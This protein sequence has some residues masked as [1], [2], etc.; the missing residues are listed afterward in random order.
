MTTLF[1]LLYFLLPSHGGLVDGLPLG[2]LETVG[3]VLVV[4]IA[5]HRGRIPGAWVAAIL[6]VAA[7]GASLA[8]PGEPGLRGSY[9]ATATA[10]G[11]HE[12]STDFKD[13]N[14]TR[15][16]TRIDFARGGHEFPLAFMNDHTRFNFMRPGEPDRRYLEFAVAWT[17][18]WWSLA[19]TH[20]L[21][22]RAPKGIGQ[23]AVDGGT[24]AT[25][26]IESG[27]VLHD[28]QVSEG[29]H[30]LHVNF[31][32]PYGAP[33]MFSAGE[34][35]NGVLTPFDANSLRTERI[36]QRQGLVAA[37]LTAIKSVGDLVVLGWLSALAVLLIVR[38]AGELWQRGMA[39]W[40]AAAYLWM[41]AATLE[42]FRFAWPWAE[43]LRIMVAGDDTM[44]YEGYARDI[45]LRG[46]LMN[47][48]Q[49]LG[50]GEPF[51]YQAFYPYFLAST[52]AVF[53]EGFFGAV[54]LQRV[55]VA[56]TVIVLTRIAMKLRDDAVWPVGVLVSGL[57]LYWKL[58]PI[59]A[60]LLSESLYVP[61]LAASTLAI[62][63]CCRTPSNR[64]AVVAGLLS[65]FTA[66]TRSTSLLAWVAVWPMVANQARRRRAGV[67]PAVALIGCTLAVFALIAIR[68]GLVSY[69]FVPAS[70]EFGITL[71]GG[72][73][74]P[75]DLQLN[76]APREALYRSLN[77]GGHTAEV[78]EYAIAA[79]GRFAGNIGHKALFALGF[80]EGY[81]P[82]WGNSPVYIAAWIAAL[83]GVVIVRR[84][85]SD[86]AAM[87][88]L[89]VALT[90]YL[91]IVIVYPKGERLIVPIHTML[92]PYAVIAADWLLRRFGAIGS[93]ATPG[94]PG[95]QPSQS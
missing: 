70:T 87:V 51:Y 8:V 42:A 80:Y 29:W 58:A 5:A 91:A 45:L 73:E 94:T 10:T 32:S 68:N 78:I 79:P 4:W 84:G 38:R 14:Y 13:A 55:L 57:F 40:P 59:S 75:P 23:I 83:A 71:R 64:N 3:I 76:A 89:I 66:I 62:V 72:N 54:F 16:D 47:G 60:D 39:A 92:I 81:A 19:G 56:A 74:P 22:L 46:V 65:G 34:V 15:V 24:V 31:S 85:S 90:Q 69:R 52:H 27:D 12:R 77:I 25:T 17:G 86:S 88:P 30:R 11:A 37:G 2:R 44:V 28:V 93:R 6:A 49:P 7:A 36:D 61:L 50:Q 20:T 95:L 43:R 1:W 26:T 21:Y 67:R 63:E 33:R 53:G 9:Y 48:G 82:G 35:V 18:W 41:A